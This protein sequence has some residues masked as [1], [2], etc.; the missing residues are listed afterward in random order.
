MGIIT[1]EGR[2]K[3]RVK[4]ILA[5]HKPQLY[6]HWPVQIGYG[7]PTLDCIGWIFGQAFAI[8]TKTPGK[9]PTPRQIQTMREMKMGGAKIFLIDGE[10]FP[11]QSL[12]VWLARQY[13][14][15]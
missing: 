2:V 15:R 14:H 7:A 11:Y 13:K 10:K 8:E 3:D 5:Q 12:E 9:K 4:R 1:P 6:A